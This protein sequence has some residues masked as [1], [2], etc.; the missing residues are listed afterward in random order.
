MATHSR[1]QLTAVRDS[2]KATADTLNA[3]YRAAPP[4]PSGKGISA[5]AWAILQV[6]RYAQRRQSKAEADLYVA[7][8]AIKC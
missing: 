1:A 7:G 8:L 4:S 3:L 2:F 5:E 6:L